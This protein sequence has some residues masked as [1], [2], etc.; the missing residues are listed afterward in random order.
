MQIVT[1]ELPA[2]CLACGE[3]TSFECDV[4]ADQVSPH[5]NASI[6]SAA[7]PTQQTAI[8]HWMESHERPQVAV[9]TLSLN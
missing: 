6:R 2:R 8:L 3:R 7:T 5:D 9:P 1:T 4:V